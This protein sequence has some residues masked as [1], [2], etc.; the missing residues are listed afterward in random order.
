MGDVMRR[1]SS[2]DYE[3]VIA[4]LPELYLPLETRDFL[5]HS[6]R[7]L[8]AL[9]P[10][11]NLAWMGFRPG[12]EPRFVSW[13]DLQRSVSTPLLARMESGLSSHPFG[14]HFASGA[15]PSTVLLQSQFPLRARRQH[16]EE[17]EDI[18]R[19][20]DLND[21]AVCVV[22]IARGHLLAVALTRKGGAFSERDR[23][24]LKLLQ[25]HL[26]R[27][28]QNASVLADLRS[29]G[30]SPLT[31]AADEF[32]LSSRECDVALWLAQGKTNPE[33]ATI[34]RMSPRTA[35][36]HVEAILRKMRA[37]NRTT[38]AVA[39][40]HFTTMRDR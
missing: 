2:H 11:D 32:G 23:T 5:E 14:Q 37:E 24:V 29:R 20:L 31:S 3:R 35:E 30:D 18:Y 6:L 28:H 1:L 4:L 7:V 17:Y 38:A 10:A 39:L 33:I 8:E 34:L 26:G 15:D 40:S 21:A 22:R 36:K 27:A 12:P 9:I 13:I 19:E 16:R 25:P